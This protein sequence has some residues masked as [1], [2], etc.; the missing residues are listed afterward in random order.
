M[1]AP[2][3]VAH[4][5]RSDVIRQG[6]FARKNHKLQKSSPSFRPRAGIHPARVCAARRVCFSPRTWAGWIPARGRN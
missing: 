2:G 3:R 1:P 5:I 6:L 4:G